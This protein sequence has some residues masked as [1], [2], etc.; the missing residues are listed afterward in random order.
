ML[1]I[2]K[3]RDDSHGVNGRNHETSLLSNGH[4]CFWLSRRF[5]FVLEGAI[6]LDCLEEGLKLVF[7]H[8]S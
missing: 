6:G 1:V 5:E 7:R 8:W 3:L 4:D 2:R